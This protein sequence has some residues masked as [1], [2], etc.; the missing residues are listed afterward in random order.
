MMPVYIYIYIALLNVFVSLNFFFPTEKSGLKF[1]YF[2]NMFKK[3]TDVKLL[4]LLVFFLLL[5]SHFKFYDRF[6]LFLF[7]RLF[8]NGFETKLRI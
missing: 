2:A 5:F 4:T 6:T 1:I 7:F 8:F 3:I